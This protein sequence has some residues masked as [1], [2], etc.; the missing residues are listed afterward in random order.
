MVD[1]ILDMTPAIKLLEKAGI[2]HKVHDYEHDAACVDFGNEAA[3]KL[4]VP[5]T[6][7]YKTLVVRSDTGQLA[8]ALVSVQDKVD[9][10]KLA[11]ALGSKK[12]DLADP[13]FAE[14]TTGYVVGGI[15]PLGGRKRLP[16]FVDNRMS[17]QQNI[18]IS[19]GKRG[20]QL[21]LAASDLIEQTQAQVV[22]LT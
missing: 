8:L 1:L 12:A 21:E 3:S 19:A 20:L 9:L 22:E 10:K 2:P 17:Q 5:L 11:H 4:N 14:K 16:V 7:M 15:S 18:F 13:T 6:Q